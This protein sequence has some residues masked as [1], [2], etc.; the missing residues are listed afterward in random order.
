M[1]FQERIVDKGI[2]PVRHQQSKFPVGYEIHVEECQKPISNRNKR[3]NA[4]N[5]PN[6]LVLRVLRLLQSPLE[7]RNEKMA[8]IHAA[9]ICPVGEEEVQKFVVIEVARELGDPS[10]NGGGY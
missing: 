7:S 3:A 9:D 8:Q 6:C 4:Y 10:L 1:L 2:Q 5:P